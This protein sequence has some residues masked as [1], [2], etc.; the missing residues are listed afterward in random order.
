[1]ARKVSQVPTT[2]KGFSDYFD[3]GADVSAILQVLGYA[4]QTERLTLPRYR[5]A[6]P[7]V[8]ELER[9]IEI[10]SGRFTL[11]SE[12]AKQQLFIAPLLLELIALFA[13]TVHIEEPIDVSPALRGSLDYLLDGGDTG[14]LVVIEA[15]LGDMYRGFKQLSAELAALDQWT[16][17]T[18][19]LLFGAVSIGNVWQF[20]V[21]DRAAKIVTQDVALFKIPGDLEDLTR[22]IVGILRGTDG[23]GSAV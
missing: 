21:L 11:T 16:D 5:G 9:K 13:F 14:N 10:G 12:S 19:S 8:A 3:T 23:D 22:V 1:M 6:L 2:V 7:F 20:A 4:H 15:K 18:S 17:S